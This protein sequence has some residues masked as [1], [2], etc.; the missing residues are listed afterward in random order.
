LRWPDRLK[1][2]DGFNSGYLFRA[3]DKEKLDAKVCDDNGHTIITGES[4]N[5]SDPYT[6]S[7][8][9]GIVKKAI[10]KEGK[11]CCIF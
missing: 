3:I 4:K 11:G 1:N 10:N 6:L 7:K 2:V 8:A 9:V 5:F